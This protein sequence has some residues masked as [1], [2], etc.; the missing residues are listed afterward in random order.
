MK[1]TT[2][3]EAL[4]SRIAP[5]AVFALSGSVLKITGDSGADTVGVTYSGT[6]GA[7]LLTIS[8]ATGTALNTTQTA[9][10]TSIVI[11]L[12]DGANT[13]T[14]STGSGDNCS[15]A[16][17]Y[18]GG[19]GADTLNL[20]DFAS[21]SGLVAKLG[22]GNDRVDL[23]EG[24]G[25]VQVNQIVFGK[26]VSI[27]LGAGN[28]SIT[29]TL[30]GAGTHAPTLDFQGALTITGGDGND[31]ISLGVTATNKAAVSV[32]KMLTFNGGK[33]TNDFDVFGTDVTLGKTTI[34]SADLLAGFTPSI[35]GTS[36]VT[37]SAGGLTVAAPANAT[38][39][40]DLEAPSIKVS[41]GVSYAGGA[42]ADTVNI[43]TVSGS[44]SSIIVGKVGISN[45]AGSNITK[46]GSL[47]TPGTLYVTGAVAVTGGI[48]SDT[49]AI[50]ST[51]G[52]ISG[53]VSAILGAG[54]SDVSVIGSGLYIGG[55]TVKA[56]DIAA[57]TDTLTL[58]GFVS[59][60]AISATL[61]A[62]AA[63]VKIDDIVAQDKFTLS[64][65]AG[66]GTIDIETDAAFTGAS[67]FFGAASITAGLGA[68]LVTIGSATPAIFLSTLK[69]NLGLLDTV[70]P[71]TSNITGTF[72]PGISAVVTGV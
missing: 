68:D 16:I 72:L 35:V 10:I 51:S 27:D 28:D 43:G 8:G 70:T 34:K 53:G 30:P 59:N 32:G 64:T 9:A 46:I 41:G 63:T 58:S 50:H 40:F 21:T 57:A 24:T 6:G 48:G 1:H 19:I 55:L 54:A 36:S 69:V 4:E 60:K 66:G 14:L 44:L 47:A 5:A 11:A 2:S 12:G 62:G 17:S 65:G 67:T 23:R 20:E 18:T 15:A 39:S 56:A 13:V 37:I 25:M 38:N 7:H 42:A 33:G 3:I 49:L 26:D 71:N 22:L 31:T 52:A 61:G 45:G 29:T